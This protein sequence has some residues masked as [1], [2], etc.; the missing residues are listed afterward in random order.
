MPQGHIYHIK[1]EFFEL[2]NDKKLMANKENDHY[3]PHF[4]AVQDRKNS[5][6]FWMIPMSSRVEKY[7]TIVESKMK[8][9]GKCNTIVLGTFAGRE[10]A[11]LIQNA[12][13]TIEQFIDHEHTVDGN[14]IR[15][16]KALE[17]KIVS[18]L[19]EVLTMHNEGI[20]LIYP[21][22]DAIYKC[23]TQELEQKHTINIHEE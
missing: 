4:F 21:D 7:R 18:N 1:N 2:V 20:H 16:H 13:P 19:Y 12:F 5:E 14:I 8:R 22:I 15:L 10:N 17:K 9:Y 11:F 6:I 3:R 23:M